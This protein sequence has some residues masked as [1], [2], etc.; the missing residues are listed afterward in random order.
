MRHLY[1]EI[2]PIGQK[3][4]ILEEELLRAGYAKK[5]DPKKSPEVIYKEL[6]LPS[7]DKKLRQL[8]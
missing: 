6:G 2:K 1:R 8:F 5:E 4:T 7:Q 3:Q